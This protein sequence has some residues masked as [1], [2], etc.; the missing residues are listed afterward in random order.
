MKT[1][2]SMLFCL[3]CVLL[4]LPMFAQQRPQQLTVQ[5]ADRFIENE[6]W[7]LDGVD[8]IRFDERRFVF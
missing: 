2:R 3:V 8:S 6:V 7:S 5:F 4:S 1:K